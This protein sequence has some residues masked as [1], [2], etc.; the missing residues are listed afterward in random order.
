MQQA[1]EDNVPQTNNL[2]SGHIEKAMGQHD[3]VGVDTKHE[4]STE[5]DAT[6]ITRPTLRDKLNKP[7]R[8]HLAF[9]SLLIMVF[10][11]SVDA[12]ALAVA[13]PTITKEVNG[14]TLEAFWA[15]IAFLLLVTIVQPIYTTLSD[16]LGRK[17]PLY[18]AFF[19]FFVGSIVFAV[20]PSLPVI[21][22]GRAIQGL[23]CGGIDVLN[24]VI[25]ADITTLKE[26]AFYIGMLSV[27]MALGT[28]LGPILGA[29]FSEYATWRWI[30]WINLPL[31][32]ICLPLTIFCLRLKPMPDTFRQQLA[33]V[34]WTGIGLFTTG[35]V[36]FTLPLSWAGAMYPWGSWRTI[37]P[38][39]IGVLVLVFFGWYESK[40]AEPMFPHRIF[41]NRTAA[42]TLA[43]SF[44]HGLVLYTL[45][46]Y[47]PLYF[48]A[49]LLKSPLDSAVSLIPFFAVLMAFTAI[50]AFAVEYS[51]RYLWQ[52]WIGW[53]LLTVGTGLFGLWH[54]EQGMAMTAS[55]QVIAGIGIGS[56]FTVLPIPMQASPE[57]TED[58]GL[59]V[60]MLVAFRLFGALIGLAIASTAFNSRFGQAIASIGNTISDIPHLNPKDALSFIPGLKGTTMPHETLLA[61]QGAYTES[62]RVVFYVLAAFGAVGAMTSLLTKELTIESEEQGKQAFNA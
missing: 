34:D 23:G 31:V 43:G 33:R 40:P 13:L 48:Q 29:V 17:I 36:L 47:L 20:A 53:V 60:G 38:L 61:V 30:G 8:F 14:T 49:I 54:I 44:I 55:F 41:R 24:E 3:A 52:I 6:E 62:F 57:K 11:V 37:V 56:L 22:L 45:I 9:L 35:A 1:S 27:P 28:V 50:A 25:I 42:A 46:S 18:A 21:I 58:Q 4:A 15:N 5:D 16:I 32:G 2:V 26:R 10:I 12:T 7:L 19:L 39:I 59:A 51:R